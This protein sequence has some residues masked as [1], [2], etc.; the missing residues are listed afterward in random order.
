MS[1]FI[2]IPWKYDRRVIHDGWKN[3]YLF[4]KDG[5]KFKLQPS[6]PEME[7]EG[8]VVILSYVKGMEQQLDGGNKDQKVGAT[9]RELS[10]EE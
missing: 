7:K 2:G 3:T 1:C 9:T 10:K 8:K 5:K 4:E 6:N